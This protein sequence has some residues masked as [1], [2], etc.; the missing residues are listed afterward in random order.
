MWNDSLR[1]RLRRAVHDLL[2]DAKRS[3]RAL[4]EC[5]SFTRNHDG[6]ARN[7]RT[8]TELFEPLG[9]AAH[10]VASDEETH[11]DHLVL[12]RPGP[13]N[14]DLLLVS[15]LDTVYPPDLERRA[16]FV[17]HEEDDLI[18]GPGVVDIKGGTITMHLV[19]SVLSRE[20]PELFERVGW[21]VL[22]N[23]AE[24][25]GSDSF[26][27]LARASVGDRTAACLVYEH[28]NDAPGGGTLV[29]TSRRGS[30]R[31]LVETRGRSAHAGSSHAR[32]ANAIRELARK[33]E[34][35]EAMTDPD[36][37]TT[38]NVGLVEGGTASNSVPAHA[39]CTVD[40]RADD[41]DSFAAAGA[42]IEAL[43]GEGEIASRTDGFRCTV[44][45]TKKPCFPPWP[46]N[47]GS[48]RLAALAARA[49]SDVG[50]VV[51]AEHR[52]GA[53]DGCHVW[54]LVPT[55]DGL[56]PIGFH[57]HSAEHD[58]E[59]GKEQETLRWSSVAE[60]TML[61]LAL[62]VRLAAR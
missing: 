26:R 48:R 34:A 45:V 62:L 23:A 15:H 49:G 50:I 30:G 28:G 52:L 31:F 17:W 57:L 42:R 5:N 9:F 27:S 4:V 56:G 20:L 11:G 13:G 39:R 25:E 35:I 21:T 6:V 19:L 8:L 16:G 37:R 12:T 54:D 41:P 47:D 58:P 14:T 32:G 22:L 60:R 38:F 61:N 29:T 36:G 18:R 55:L 43:A 51:G 10:S 59:Q 2:D 40:L 53:S 7:A 44:A 24:E 3:L 46:D 33:I 1:S